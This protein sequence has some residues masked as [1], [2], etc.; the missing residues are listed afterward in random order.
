VA[1]DAEVTNG[2][3]STNGEPAEGRTDE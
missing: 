1:S 2:T 3:P